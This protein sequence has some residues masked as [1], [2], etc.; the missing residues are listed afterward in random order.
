MKIKRHGGWCYFE[1]SYLSTRFEVSL[2]YFDK[3]IGANPSRITV[4]YGSLWQSWFGS[5]VLQNKDLYLYQLSGV[6]IG[7]LETVFCHTLKHYMTR[8]D[9]KHSSIWKKTEIFLDFLKMNLE[10]GLTRRA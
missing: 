7:I 3:R 9:S 6:A 5:N 4:K 10:G 1:D 2:L 8:G